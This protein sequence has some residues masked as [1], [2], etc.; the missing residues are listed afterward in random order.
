MADIDDLKLKLAAAE[1]RAVASE[2]RFAALEN[3][4]AELLEKLNR[5]SKNSNKPPSTESPP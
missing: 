3:Q 4:V 5:N 2:A 1:A